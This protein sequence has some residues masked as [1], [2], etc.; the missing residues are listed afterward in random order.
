MPKTLYHVKLTDSERKRLTRLVENGTAPAKTIL[1]ANILLAADE[2]HNQEHY[3]EKQIAK[4]YSVHFQTVHSVRKTFS[5]EGL[6]TA[7]G[8][9]KRKTPPV[10]SKLTGE[11]EAKIIALSCSE[12]PAGYSRWTLRLLADK[13]VELNYIDS[14]SHVT[15]GSIL[16]KTN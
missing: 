7:L 12:P 14:I 9:K 5:Q 16:K 1:H 2:L 4:M 3:N 8:R 13:S 6:E 11:L 10:P 15:V